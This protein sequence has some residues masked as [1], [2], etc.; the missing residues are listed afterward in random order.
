M[1]PEY[2]IHGYLSVKTDVFS[3]GILVLEIL[4]GRKNYDRLL[5]AEKANL[6]NY[7]REEVIMKFLSQ[8]CHFLYKCY[9]F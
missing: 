5:D 4:G 2:V 8:L 1:A 3:F 6:L 7:V 9:F